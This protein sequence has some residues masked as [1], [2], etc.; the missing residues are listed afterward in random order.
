MANNPA[1]P[2]SFRDPSGFLFERSGRLLRQVNTV[3]QHDYERLMKSG[4][5]RR[6]VDAGLLVAH[7]ETN[8]AP[9]DP[10]TAYRVIAPERVDFVSYPY[11]WSFSQL[12]DAALATLEIQEQAIRSGMILKDASAYNIQFH[13]GKPTLIDSLSFEI[14]CE[15]EPW[16][17]YRQFCQHFLAPLAL[18]ATTDVRLSQLLRVYID[19]VPLDLTARLLPMRTRFNLGLLTHLHMHA[20]AQKRYAGKAAAV[21]GANQKMSKVS[22]LGLVDNLRATVAGLKWKPA[23]TEWGEYY[24]ATNYS[25]AAFEAKKKIVDACLE[26]VSPTGV[27]DL[28]A[29]TGV[30]SRLASCRGIFTVAWDIDPAAVETG[31]RAMRAGGETHLLPLVIDLTNPSPGL[32]WENREREALAGRGPVEMILALA[33]IHHL[34]ISN[35]VPLERLAA[36]FAGLCTWLVVEF[37]PKSDSQVQRLL[38]SRKDI[39]PTYTRDG[40]ETAFTQAFE[41]CGRF[42][43]EGSQRMVYLMRRREPVL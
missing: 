13:R 41:I 32:G 22:L 9:A 38:S 39:F 15:G 3:Y 25:D 37:V 12:K 16:V 26:R 1:H 40:F 17:A 14:Y 18:M 23:G 10:V 2:A 36:F 43:V 42:P 30:F 8:D 20:A 33:L 4:L 27:W 6:L 11:E 19:G 35:N 31:Y 21:A 24:Q 34:A 7:E 28:G 29:N 5:Y